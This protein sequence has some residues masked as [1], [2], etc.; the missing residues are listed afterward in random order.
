MIRMF[1]AATL[2][3]VACAGTAQAQTRVKAAREAA[4][5]LFGRFG[6]KAGRSVPELAGRIE[7]VAARHGDDAI[8]AIRKGGPSA[9][10]LIEAAGPDGAKAVRVLATHGE[11]GASR[12]LSRP[13]A[14]QQFLQHGDDAA[15]ALVRHPG[16]AEPL[17]ARAGAPAV[18]A[19]AAVDPRNGRRLNMLLDGELAAAGRHPEVLGVVAK[20]GDR[21]VNF[22]W[23]NKGALAAGAALTAFLANPE[24]F[25]DGTSKLAGTLSHGVVTPV[26]QE[27]GRAVS[28]LIWGIVCLVAGLGAA[29]A[30]VAVKKPG[31]VAAAVKAAAGLRRGGA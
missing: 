4:E 3:V 24:P 23:E 29:G 17:V 26:V 13:A 7:A 15:T 19:L 21:A 25:L 22:L 30:L 6:S 12:V 9:C 8:L 14:M 28:N 2:A 10:G 5:W 1:F 20:H 11:L 27:T 18:K 31:L 16:V